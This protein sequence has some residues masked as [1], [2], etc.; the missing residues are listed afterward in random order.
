VK[1]TPTVVT[2]QSLQQGMSVLGARGTPW[3][4]GQR[5][6]INSEGGIVAEI[7]IEEKKAKPPWLLILL[8]LLIAGVIGWWLWTNRGKPDTETGTPSSTVTDT[9]AGTRSP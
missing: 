8:L 2:E 6:N 9:T 3:F 1:E 5:V 7:R 4:S